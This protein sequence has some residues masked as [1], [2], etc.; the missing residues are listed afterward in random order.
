MEDCEVI[1]IYPFKYNIYRKRFEIKYRSKC[2]KCNAINYHIDDYLRIP[3]YN[4]T[5]TDYFHCR[6]CNHLLKTQ[7]TRNNFLDVV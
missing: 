6:I 1:K 5:I 3:D 4:W 2:K 7:I